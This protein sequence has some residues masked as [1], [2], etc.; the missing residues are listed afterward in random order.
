MPE[1]RR[2]G[3]AQRCEPLSQC[4]EPASRGREHLLELER[5]GQL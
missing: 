5:S 4:G 3:E 1:K 2:Y